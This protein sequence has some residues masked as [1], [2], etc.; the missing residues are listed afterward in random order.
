M[1]R[2][3]LRPADMSETELL[4]AFYVSLRLLLLI[5]DNIFCRVLPPS[6]SYTD[7]PCVLFQ[8]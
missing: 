5:T 7:D 3:N 2:A 8:T 4:Q 6:Y 1:A